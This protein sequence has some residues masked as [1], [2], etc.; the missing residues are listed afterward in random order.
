MTDAYHITLEGKKKGLPP[1]GHA[2]GEEFEK[3]LDYANLA[4]LK[5]AEY[6]K[7]AQD[8]ARIGA[9]GA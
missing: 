6:R 5:E 8:V 7:K 2:D 4:Q 9:K 1:S 3:K